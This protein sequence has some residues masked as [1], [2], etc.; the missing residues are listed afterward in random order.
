[1][2]HDLVLYPYGLLRCSTVYLM[3]IGC[4]PVRVTFVRDLY[5]CCLCK[6]YCTENLKILQLYLGQPKWLQSQSVHSISLHIHFPLS[7]MHMCHKKTASL[8][9]H[10]C[11]AAVSRVTLTS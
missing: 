4:M 6:H 8:L 2:G 3:I 11:T 1:M 9:P 7:R 5:V 10:S